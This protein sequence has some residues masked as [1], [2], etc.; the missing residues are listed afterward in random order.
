MF[1]GANYHAQIPFIDK[2]K[3]KER[4]TLI[5]FFSDVRFLENKRLNKPIT[6]MRSIR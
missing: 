5:T 4:L 3:T 6:T 2:D 1:D